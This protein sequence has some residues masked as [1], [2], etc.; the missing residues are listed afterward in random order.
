M[1]QSAHHLI[2]AGPKYVGQGAWTEGQ[3]VPL[4][5]HHTSIPMHASLW[6][7]GGGFDI[8]LPFFKRQDC[9]LSLSK[10][11]TPSPSRLLPKMRHTSDHTTHHWPQET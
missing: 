5:Q 6:G 2:G 4:M 8:R 10:V 1:S 9:I 7:T 11:P 3:S